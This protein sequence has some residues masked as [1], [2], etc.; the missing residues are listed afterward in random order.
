MK[1]KNM[2]LAKVGTFTDSRGKE[3]TFTPEELEATAKA[4]NEFYKQGKDS[5]IV[6]THVD[7]ETALLK[8]QVYGYLS[9]YKYDKETEMLVAEAD[10]VRGK[11]KEMSSGK[12]RNFSMRRNPKDKR[13]INLAIVSESAIPDANIRNAQIE[14]LSAQYGEVDS[15]DFSTEGGVIEMEDK[16]ETFS[17]EKEK[18]L[19]QKFLDLFTIQKKEINEEI[20]K[21]LEEFKA[22]EKVEENKE[23]DM[24]NMEE[25]NALKK[26]AAEYEEFKAKIDEENKKKLAEQRKKDADKTVEDFCAGGQMLPCQKELALTILNS[27]MAEDFKQYVALSKLVDFDTDLESFSNTEV[28]LGKNVVNKESLAQ[29]IKSSELKMEL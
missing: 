5:A 25:F 13:I 12:F 29:S 27:D 2:V 28:T 26:I 18:N 19:V 24:E 21:T 7:T 16:E 3:V 6:L 14:E 10:I 20:K 8:D 17:A 1:I 22:P 15:V 23:E 4:N 11:E 9:N